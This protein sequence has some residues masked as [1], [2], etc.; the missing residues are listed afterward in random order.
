[1][2]DQFENPFN[3]LNTDLREVPPEM[4]KRVMNDVAVAKLILEM[5]M[6][7]TSNYASILGSLFKTNA[8]ENP[9]TNKL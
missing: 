8:Y 5:A 4:R 9:K 2:S 3:Q 1:M 7:L 6:L